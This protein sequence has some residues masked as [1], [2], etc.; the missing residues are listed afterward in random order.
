MALLVSKNDVVEVV[1]KFKSHIVPSTDIQQ[2]KDNPESEF[3]STCERCSFS[4]MIRIDPED[5]NYYL[6]S[7]YE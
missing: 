1:C 5:P 3:S 6:V 4:I 2:L 7:D